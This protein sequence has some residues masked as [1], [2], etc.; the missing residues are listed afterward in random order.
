MALTKAEIIQNI[1][2]ELGFPQKKSIE[3]VEQ[4]LGT[5]KSTLVSG[6]DVLVSGFGKFCVN[7]KK[8]KV[9][10]PAEYAGKVV[11]I[12]Y[13]VTTNG[14]GDGTFSNLLLRNSTWAVLPQS[15]E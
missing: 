14:P 6:E 1:H 5:I 9:I 2:Q 4:L 15:I 8:V 7:Y 12:E 11:R 3:L 10:L 13:R